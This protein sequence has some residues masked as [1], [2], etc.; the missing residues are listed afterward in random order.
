[1]PFKLFMSQKLILI[2]FL[3]V[4][5]SCSKEEFDIQNLNGNK[6]SALGHS[7]MG[8]RSAY[9]R[10]SYESLTKSLNLGADG[11]EIDLQLTKDNVLIAFHDED[12]SESTNIKGLVRSLTWSEIQNA[13]YTNPLYTSYSII[14]MDQLLSNTDD[15]HQYNYTLDC[16]YHPLSNDD[17]QY[18][19]DYINALSQLITKFNLI[20]NAY[21]ES[22]SE[23]FLRLLQLENN[24]FN[25]FINPYSF[26][27]G[28]ETANKLGLFGI[29]MST[30]NI[31]EDQIEAAHDNNL[32]IAIWGVQT[33]G[34]NTRAVNKN[35]DFIQTDYMKILW[36]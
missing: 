19:T 20:N 22:Q 30:D 16:K 10:N 17:T 35:P 5:L 25:L 14:S 34:D 9:P 11:I 8:N 28:L 12:L 26:E 6:I 31:S 3:I 33:N 18:E 27:Y 36:K 4:T 2:S 23:D 1:M 15:M 29:S 7:G 32:F 24:E 21:I 13:Y